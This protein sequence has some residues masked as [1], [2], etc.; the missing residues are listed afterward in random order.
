M[1]FRQPVVPTE[2]LTAIVA[3]KRQAFFFLPT[4]VAFHE[5]GNLPSRSIAFLF[6]ERKKDSACI[7]CRETL[8]M[9]KNSIGFQRNWFSVQ[10]EAVSG[11]GIW[12]Q[13][14]ALDKQS[15][16]ESKSRFQE[17]AKTFFDQ[18]GGSQ[19]GVARALLEY[20]TLM[21][22]YALVQDARVLKS[23]LKFDDSLSSFAKAAEILRATVHFGFAAAYVS[24][25]ASLETA[26]EMENNQDKF[27]GFRN[28]IAL[29]EQ[30]KLALSFR[31]DRHPKIHSIDV[32]IKFAISRALLIEADILKE[33]GESSD[34]RK[35]KEQSRNVEQD[36][37][38]L[39]GTR[40]ALQISKFKIDYFPTGQ[41]G[42][43]AT[44][45]SFITTFPERTTLWIGNVGTHDALI[46]SLG[47]SSLGKVL[48]P[49]QS[50][51]WPMIPEF[52]GKLRIS[53]TDQETKKNY[54]EGCLT[55]I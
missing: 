51:E 5:A 39:A 31:D 16:V 49:S 15:L 11:F 37:R 55:V 35:K 26:F 54:N 2:R 1:I 12:K 7:L 34:S 4:K 6:A 28:S 52:K 13:A 53:Y 48:P 32:M 42:E 9:R 8:T 45:G 44:T 23:Q 40:S 17:A 22:S 30:S 43:R 3:S 41:E 21:D 14:L 27:E 19:S 50:I 18:A 20:S 36:F 25:C 33:R 46:H 38:K 29:F 10:M 47:E 24:A